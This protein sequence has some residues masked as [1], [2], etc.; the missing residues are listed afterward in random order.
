M[1]RCDVMRVTVLTTARVYAN[2]GLG[3]SRVEGRLGSKYTCI[4][5]MASSREDLVLRLDER[6]TPIAG[7]GV[8]HTF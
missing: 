1:L 2:L 3:W 4:L 5:R 6:R 8:V 7:D